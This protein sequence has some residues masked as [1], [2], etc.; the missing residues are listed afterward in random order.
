MGSIDY[1]PQERHGTASPPTSSQFISSSP[2]HPFRF[3]SPSPSLYLFLRIYF[4]MVGK[5][6]ALSL[7]NVTK[8][9][10]PKRHNKSNP[11]WEEIFVFLVHGE[12]GIF[13][14]L[15]FYSIANWIN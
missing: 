3:I 4:L 13:L 15:I 6:M 2:S 14:L 12:T 9:T 10:A 5:Y 7:G 1:P 11:K 8:K